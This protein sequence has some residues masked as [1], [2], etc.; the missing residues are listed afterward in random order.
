MGER[1]GPPDPLYT[2]HDHKSPIDVPFRPSAL[3]TSCTLFNRRRKINGSV[4]LYLIVVEA[5]VNY[6]GR[7][8]I[9]LGTILSYLCSSAKLM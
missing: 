5:F 8:R 6:T 9:I 3:H 4:P 7:L 1:W 2:Q